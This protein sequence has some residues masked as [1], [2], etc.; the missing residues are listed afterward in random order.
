[1]LMKFS[2][3]KCTNRHLPRA[4][5]HFSETYGE[6]CG[7]YQSCGLCIP[8]VPF[9][10]APPYLDSSHLFFSSPSFIHK[11]APSLSRMPECASKSPFNCLNWNVAI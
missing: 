11:F 8:R 9:P 5:Q 6:G 3:G 4:E 7:Y 10:L 2:L 1:M